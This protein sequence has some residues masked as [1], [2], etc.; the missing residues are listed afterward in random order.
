MIEKWGMETPATEGR[1]GRFSD[2]LVRMEGKGKEE[3][4]RDRGGMV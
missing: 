3:E 2:G 1:V 4:R